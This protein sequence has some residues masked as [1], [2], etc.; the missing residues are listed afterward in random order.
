MKTGT[1]RVDISSVDTSVL[2]LQAGDSDPER[3]SFLN[4]P[5]SIQGA[6][7]QMPCFI[8]STN[9][10]VHETLRSGFQESPLFTGMISGRGPRYCPSI[11]DKLRVFPDKDSHQ[12]FLEPE[13]RNTNEYYLQ[14]FSSSP[15]RLVDAMHKAGLEQGR[16]L[17]QAMQ[18]NMIISIRHS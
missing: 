3:F 18:W 10:A 2:L 15:L 11:E 12:L 1:P 13:G 5:S 7:P 17:N 8:L 9:E 14:G 6:D 4:I 16:S